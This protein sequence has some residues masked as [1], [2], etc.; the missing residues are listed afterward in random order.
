MKK[1]PLF[2]ATAAAIMLAVSLPGVSPASA[3]TTEASRTAQDERGWKTRRY[4]IRVME[5]VLEGA[6]RHGAELLTAELRPVNPNLM[7]LTGTARARG[8][9]LDGYG[10]FFSVEIPALRPSVMWSINTMAL[11]P[12]PFLARSL[13]QLRRQIAS[14]QE[15]GARARLEQSITQI[16]RQMQIEPTLNRPDSAARRVSGATV[17]G[18][19]ELPPAAARVLPRNPNELYTDAVKDALVDAMLDYS[20]PMAL[21]PDEWLTVAARDADGPLTPGEPYDAVTLVLRISGAHLADFRAGRITR[22]AARA[23]VE[24]REF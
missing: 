22:E 16:E 5:G 15:P 18:T 3:Q 21:Q 6:V 9:V 19:D 4:Q 8:I 10:I 23:R 12:D 20:G 7:L 24:V 11:E 13:A 14:L 2:T 1:H 17:E